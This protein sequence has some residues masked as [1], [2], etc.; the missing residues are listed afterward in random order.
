[1]TRRDFEAARQHMLAQLR[2]WIARERE[3]R[4]QGTGSAADFKALVND[5]ARKASLNVRDTGEAGQVEHPGGT[6][7]LRFRMRVEGFRLEQL[8]KF[9]VSVEQDWPGSKTRE[10]SELL[11]DEKKETWNGTLI[12]AIFKTTEQTP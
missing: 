9:L 3:G 7:E 5:H 8:M 12:L 1:M 11:L 2:D 4:N 6:R 10:I